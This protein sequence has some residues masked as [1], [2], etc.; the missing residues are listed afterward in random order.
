MNKINP[1][2]TY[3]HFKGNEYE[4]VCIGKNSETEEVMVVYKDLSDDTK[5][6]IRPLTMFLDIKKDENGTEVQR[7]Q[8]IG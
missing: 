3:K 4:I 5:I 1:G 7:F 2:Q 8:K 6:W